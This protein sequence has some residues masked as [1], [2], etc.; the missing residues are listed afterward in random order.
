[1]KKQFFVMA[2]LCLTAAV[3]VS[4]DN[5]DLE[6][7]VQQ[8]KVYNAKPETSGELNMGDSGSDDKNLDPGIGDENEKDGGVFGGRKRE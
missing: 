8:E 6:E 5:D 7:Q 2:F 1:M 4:C 3:F